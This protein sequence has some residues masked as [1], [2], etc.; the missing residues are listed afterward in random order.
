MSNDP[1]I[2]LRQLGQAGRPNAAQFA[3]IAPVAPA[4]GVQAGEFADLLRR[5][6][7]GTLSSNRPVTI[8]DDAGLQL[9][10]DQLARLA[11]A[12][13]RAEAAG[14]RKV[15]VT[16]DDRRVIL[17]VTQRAVLSAASAQGGVIEGIDGVMDLAGLLA[18]SPDKAA[19]LG[20]P[21]AMESPAVA[22]LLSQIHHRDR[23]A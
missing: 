5:A 1:A 14:L 16:I 15:L 11:L 17:D 3:P 22:R 6:R 12:A 13:D 23:A 21:T 19:P 9:T 10:E 4:G 7:D 8:A 20:P 18:P 2:M